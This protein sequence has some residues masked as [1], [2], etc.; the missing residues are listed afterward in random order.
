MENK[1]KNRILVVDDEALIRL[2]AEDLLSMLGYKVFLAED[3][4]NCLEIIKKEDNDID[5][6]ILD[7]KMPIMNGKECFFELQKIHPG[8]KVLFSSGLLSNEEKELTNHD[9]VV[10]IINKP[11]TIEEMHKKLDSIFNPI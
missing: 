4:H 7:M 10:G 5:L 6:V 8:M 11:Y 1:R 9:N 3:G 2:T